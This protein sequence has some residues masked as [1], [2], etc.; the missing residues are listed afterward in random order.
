LLIISAISIS[1]LLLFDNGKLNLYTIY[2]LKYK[3]VCGINK[4]KTKEAPFARGWPKFT[5]FIKNS[6]IS[7]F[8]RRD[9]GSDIRE[10]IICGA[11]EL[12]SGHGYSNVRVEA[13]AD[14][15][16]VSKKTIYNHFPSKPS[17]FGA[18]ID[19]NTRSLCHRLDEFEFDSEKRLNWLKKIFFLIILCY[20]ELSGWVL[21]AAGYKHNNE[22]ADQFE[23]SLD[24]IKQ[25]IIKRAKHFLDEDISKATARDDRYFR[26]LFS[27]VAAVV[28]GVI[29]INGS[30]RL[31]ELEQNPLLLNLK[32]M[33]DAYEVE[34][35]GHSLDLEDP[36]YED[37]RQRIQE[38]EKESAEHRKVEDDLRRS[39]ARL[40]LAM[41]ISD[42]MPWEINLQTCKWHC[43]PEDYETYRHE[44]KE[45]FEETIQFVESLLRYLKG[46]DDILSTKEGFEI[47][48]HPGDRD[49]LFF[50]GKAVIDGEKSAYE[51]DFRMF[52][53]EGIWAW[54]YGKAKVTKWDKEGNPLILSGI[55]IDITERKKVEEALR[56]REARL[57]SQTHKLEETN[58]A[59]RVLL[60]SREGDK[61][62]FEEK[63]V[64]NL[65]EMVFPFIE[66][67]KS[68]RLDERQTV[69]L[70]IV[71]SHLDDMTAPFL[72]QLSSKYS[73]LTPAEIKVAV[74]VKEGRTTKEIAGLM[75]SSIDA[76]NF[77][78]NSLRKKFGL[79][80]S[81][82]NLRTHL[83][84]LS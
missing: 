12:F 37:L 49:R 39:K 21:S 19:S 76:V 67:L 66:K 29:H 10:K 63:I 74:F 14:F 20:R 51:G 56:E 58:T 80:N 2:S 30:C 69:Y 33:A 71:K 41:E 18:V 35:T 81:K 52:E 24:Q 77:H 36:T 32:A 54:Y 3:S 25:K 22:I 13:I 75:N 61:R 53:K 23:K 65:K 45:E 46:T 16:G 48:V 84:S 40:S 78:R 55:T 70:D 38:L 9:M 68:S 28:D 59:L 57:A 11:A 8:D 43:D 72:H 1:K 50:A 82:T 34:K 64:T 26:A 31:D 17:L 42:A 73:N 7:A 27:L 47:P 5:L 62:E 79:V 6:I 15:V 4:T 83:L 44:T 60:K